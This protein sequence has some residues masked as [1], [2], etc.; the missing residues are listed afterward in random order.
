[1]YDRF[2]IPVEDAEE[3][4][5]EEIIGDC[6]TWKEPEQ[7][8]YWSI[9][10]TPMKCEISF[11]TK[12]KNSPTTFL[13]SLN[14]KVVEVSS[15]P[16]STIIVSCITTDSNQLEP[17]SFSYIV[18]AKRAVFSIAMYYK[19]LDDTEYREVQ[20]SLEIH[21]QEKRWQS[22]DG[23]QLPPK[24]L[25]FCLNAL[26]N[27]FKHMTIKQQ[28]KLKNMLPL[29]LTRDYGSQGA[30]QGSLVLATPETRRS[31]TKHKTTPVNARG[32]PSDTPQTGVRTRSKKLEAEDEE[33]PMPE[34]S[35]A[36]ELVNIPKDIG[37][38]VKEIDY[39]ESYKIYEG[40]WAEC[41]DSYIF[42]IATKFKISID[43]L[44]TP[45]ENLNI[46]GLEEAG[47]KKTMNYLLEMPDPDKKMTLCAMPINVKE[48]PSSF[49]V[50]KDGK[51]YMINGQHSVEASK[52]MQHL[53]T[54]KEKAKKFKEWD[55][56]IVW[57]PDNR[58][59][60]KYCH[61]TTE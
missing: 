1:M 43:Q 61:T 36:S 15:G 37:G 31:H 14:E 48:K 50:I 3:Y 46:R 60:R 42:G 59:I 56:F 5:D 38:S 10:K 27:S 17:Y 44:E 49:D 58:I 45:P 54:L 20:K 4:G 53:S 24:K 22:D 47:V 34:N 41:K 26:N 55:C 28:N 12:W 39:Q 16:S 21:I 6:W 13:V 19:S 8:E 57:N 29:S 2:T 33:E 52:K 40:Y 23:G 11:I 25:V 30:S 51:F 32:T 7:V 18:D 9:I 35:M